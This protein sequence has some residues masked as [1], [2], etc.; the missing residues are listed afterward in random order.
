LTFGNATYSAESLVQTLQGLADAMTARDA[1]Q[2]KA[3]DANL[4]VHDATAKVGPV[5]RAYRRYLAVTYGNATETLA[6]YGLAPRQG[7]GAADRR[8]E[9]RIGCEGQG[10]AQ[11]AGDHERQAET[12]GEGRGDGRGHHADHAAGVGSRDDDGSAHGD[13][14]CRDVATAADAEPR[15]LTGARASRALPP[16][17]R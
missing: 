15:P 7:A 10:H 3:K 9:R 4:S 2:V 17:T 1:A 14:P 12:V 11:G 16:H 13:G 8:A 6:D 5:L